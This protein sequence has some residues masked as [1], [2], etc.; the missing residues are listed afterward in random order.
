MLENRPQEL[1]CND[2]SRE[3]IKQPVSVDVVTRTG[4]HENRFRD[5]NAVPGRAYKRVARKAR[6]AQS[7]QRHVRTMGMLTNEAPFRK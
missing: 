1:L 4:D 7:L 5:L 3:I 2:H 6:G